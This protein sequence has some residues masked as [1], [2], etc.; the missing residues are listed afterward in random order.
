MWLT[1]SLQYVYQWNVFTVIDRYFG[2]CSGKDFLDPVHGCTKCQQNA[3]GS[4]IG[5]WTAVPAKE[6]FFKS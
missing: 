1:P 5:T 4:F 3:S 6:H 2:A